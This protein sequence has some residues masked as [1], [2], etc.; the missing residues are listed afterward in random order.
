M[1]IWI[2]ISDW[3]ERE[4]EEPFAPA[5]MPEEGGGISTTERE[6]E[7][8][9]SSQLGFGHKDS[10]QPHSSQVKPLWRLL[11]LFHPSIHRYEKLIIV[12][13]KPGYLPT[14][15]HDANRIRSPS[16]KSIDKR[17]LELV[18]HSLKLLNSGQLTVR[19]FIPADVEWL[20][21]LRP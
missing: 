5:W 3:R 2:T 13:Q 18:F 14:S 9:F 16:R 20:L 4:R 6:R 17:F 10:S 8:Q 12:P 15:H 7:S 19:S 21:N 11:S 1:T